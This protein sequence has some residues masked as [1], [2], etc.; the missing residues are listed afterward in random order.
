MS[1]GDEAR[2]RRSPKAWAP[3]PAGGGKGGPARVRVRVRRLDRGGQ[4]GGWDGEGRRWRAAARRPVLTGWGGALA[5]PGAG[6]AQEVGVGGDGG[7]PRE[8]GAVRGRGTGKRLSAWP[9]V[10][11]GECRRDPKAPERR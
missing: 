3:R 9:R 7:R 10:S 2:G 11:R 1:R 6:G 4:A 5:V 8:G